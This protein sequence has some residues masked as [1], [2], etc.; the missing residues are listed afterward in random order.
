M[1]A[2][3][4]SPTMPILLERLLYKSRSKA[5]ADTTFNL[6]TIL[7]A[8]QRNNDRD[9]LTGALAAYGRFYVQAVEGSPQALDRLVKR[10]SGDPRHCDITIMARSPISERT[11]DN[12][13][14]ASVR[15]TPAT[16]PLLIQLT[17]EETKTADQMID[18]LRQAVAVSQAAELENLAPLPATAP[19]GGPA[20]IPVTEAARLRT[21]HSLG[22]LDTPEEPAFDLAVQMARALTRAQ[23]AVVSLLDND[24]QWFKARRGIDQP[25]TARSVAFCSYTILQDEVLWVED[26]RLDPRFC[27][28]PLVTG[29]PGIRFYAGAPIRVGQHNIGTLCVFDPEPRAVNLDVMKA[30][31]EAATTLSRHIVVRSQTMASQALLSH[32]TDAGIVVNHEGVITL[33][34]GGAEAMFGWSSDEAIGQ[35]LDIILPEDM[36]DQ[37]SAGFARYMGGADGRI[38]GQPIDLKAARRNGEVFPME[39]TL[40]GWDRGGRREVGALIRDTTVRVEQQAQLAAALLDAQEAERTKSRFLATMNHELRTPLNGILGLGHVLAASELTAYQRKLVEGIADSGTDLERLVRNVV[41]LSADDPDGEPAVFNLTNVIQTTVTPYLERARA[42]GLTAEL[43]LDINAHVDVVGQAGAAVDVLAALLDNAVKFTRQ[44]SITVSVQ[45]RDDVVKI[46]IVDTGD[47]FEI[48]DLE[49]L[50]LP[51]EQGDGRSTRAFDGAGIGLS[52][53]RKT[54]RRLGGT[55][56]VQSVS[57]RGSSFTVSLPFSSAETLSTAA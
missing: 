4:E 47:G 15:V 53:V 5:G 50:F 16:E 46:S 12:W 28:N 7:G 8:S 19:N 40:A 37:H 31:G 30:L 57:G 43:V 25:E 14:M 17:D 33:W 52:L 51:F 22:L 55:I 32:T 21:L 13:S 54:L 35:S 41:A 11:F 3:D 38:F 18:L 26:A 39:L 36:A 34:A 23:M 2:V 44:G 20:P 29:A 9:G 24:R 27:G 56:D 10:L 1:A 6:A 48:S 42:K 49:R 45:Q